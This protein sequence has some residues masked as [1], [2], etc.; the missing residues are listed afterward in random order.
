MVVLGIFGGGN[1]GGEGGG[2]G[3]G[4]E[5]GVGGGDEAAC[6]FTAAVESKET[7]LAV[8]TVSGTIFEKSPLRCV[9]AV[10]R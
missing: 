1:G 7:V 9:Y 2:E 5:G 6:S 8:K 10:P 4:G 3:G